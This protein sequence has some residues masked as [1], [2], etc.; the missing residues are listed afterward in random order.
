MNR[1]EELRE[2]YDSHDVSAEM[3]QGHWETDVVDDP[4]IT[5]S[6][7]LP[8]SL[9]D[10]VREQAGAEHAKPSAWIRA[11]IE[12][13]RAGGVDLELRVSA[14]ESLLSTYIIQLKSDSV[15]YPPPSPAE[16]P[17]KQKFTQPAKDKTFGSTG[18]LRVKAGRTGISGTRRL[19]AVAQSD[20]KKAMPPAVPKGAV[21]RKSGFKKK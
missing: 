5:T 10:W 17:A 12:K 7:R 6:L 2:H 14:L 15:S 8:K 3:E 1:I 21:M 11:L 13:T 20:N 19:A 18:G 16:T 9:L 4:M